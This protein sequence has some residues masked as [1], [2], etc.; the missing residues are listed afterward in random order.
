[1]KP[2]TKM[3]VLGFKTLYNVQYKAG[4]PPCVQKPEDNM[5]ALL[6]CW[7]SAERKE[8]SPS[9][10]VCRPGPGSSQPEQAYLV[11]HWAGNSGGPAFAD[12]NTN[13]VRHVLGNTFGMAV[14]DLYGICMGDLTK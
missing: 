12:L 10:S 14:G 1:M 6:A 4:L 11:G 2:F 9:I 3:L 13:K 8:T 5:P 7:N